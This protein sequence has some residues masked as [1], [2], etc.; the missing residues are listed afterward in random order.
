MTLSVKATDNNK[1]Q[2]KKILVPIDGSEYSFNAAKYAIKL[3]K[4]ENAQ[5]YCIHVIGSVPY[6]YGSSPHAIDQYFKDL[7]QKVQS[8]FDKIKDMAKNEGILGIKTET[9]TDVRSVIG[10]IIDYAVTKEVDLIVIGTRG[11][12]GLKRFFIGSVANGV[13]QHAHCSVLLVR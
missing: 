3:A 11:R 5:L 13:V 1:V 10:S 8:W 6:G 2:I 7:E 4:D 9:F 12:T